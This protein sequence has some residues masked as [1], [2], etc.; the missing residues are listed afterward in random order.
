MPPPSTAT[1]GRRARRCG[2]LASAAGAEASAAEP[3]TAAA[4][5]SSLRRVMS[6]MS[7]R[8]HLDRLLECRAIL[9]RDERLGDAAERPEP[10]RV[11]AGLV[12]VAAGVRADGV[13]AVGGL[14]RDAHRLLE[15]GA[16]RPAPPPQRRPAPPPGAAVRARPAAALAGAQQPAEVGERVAV[17]AVLPG[18]S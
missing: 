11:E 18:R 1:V 3:A 15:R 5:R 8:P 6:F 16:R 4:S 13:A 17:P 12:A 9:P 2:A 10:D 7:A 14:G